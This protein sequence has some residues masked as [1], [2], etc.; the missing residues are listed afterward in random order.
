MAANDSS[1][2]GPGSLALARLGSPELLNLDGFKLRSA[3]FDDG[4]ALD[5]CFT[6]DE[7]DSVAPPLEWSAPPE[8]SMELVLV[9]EDPDVAGKEPACHWIVWGLAPQKGQLLEGETPPRVGKN[10]QGNSEW[11]LPRLPDDEEH[12]FFFQL[13]AVDTVLNL[14]PGSSRKALFEAIEGHV[15]GM[16]ML[17]ATYRRED[18]EEEGDWDDVDIENIDFDGN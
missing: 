16:T 15:V 9:V 18:D 13:F 11:M 5:P 12:S 8:G 1:R 4:E 14:R 17:T 2:A 10:G 7:E 3:A 6:A